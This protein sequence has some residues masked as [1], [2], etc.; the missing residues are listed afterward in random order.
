MGPW[1]QYKLDSGISHILVD[2][3]QDTNSEQWR[4]VDA[5]VEDFFN[6][7]S[8]AQRPRTVFAVGDQKQSIF[9]FQGADPEL[10]IDT[11][12]KYALRAQTVQ[13]AFR[14]VPL[15]TSFRTLRN[16]LGAVDQVFT[17]DELRQGVLAVDEP[18]G[19]DTARAE[20]G[21]LVTLWPPIQ[22]IEEPVDPD[23]WPTQ[24][25]DALTKNAPRRVAERIAREIRGWLDSGRPLGPRGRA[26]KADDILILVQV[27]SVLFHEIIR[28]LVRAGIPTPG[29]DRL[30]VTTHIGVLDLM[31]LGDVLLNP[32]DDLQLAALLRSPLFEVSEDELLALA[33]PRPEKATLWSAMEQSSIPSVAAAYGQIKKWR[34]R[35]DFERPF[36]FFSEVLYAAGGLKKFRARLGAEIDDVAAQFLDLALNHEQSEQPSLQGFL[37]ELR[38]R[39]III[40]RELAEAGTGVRVMTVHG[41]KGLEAPIVILADAATTEKGRGGRTIYMSVVPPLFFHASADRLH[42]PETREDKLEADEA[43]KREY[44]RKLYVAMTR[45]EDELYVTG[46]LTKQGKVEGSWYEAIEQ[47]L[48]PEAE[49]LTD[50]EG[51][52]SALVYPAQRDAPMPSGASAEAGATES[53]TPS[54]P[55][56]PSYRLRRIVRP[57]SAFVDADPARVLETTV[58]AI[59]ATQDPE[60]A[61][62]KGLALHALLQHL[63]RID[64]ALRPAVAAK[65]LPVL[66]PGHPEEHAALAAKAQS[67]LGSASFADLFGP[68]SRAEVPILAQGRRGSQPVTI[69]GRI[70]RLLVEPGR[71]LIVDFKSDANVPSRGASGLSGAARAICAGCRPAL[72][73]PR[74]RSRD[75][76]D[77]PGIIDESEF[78][79]H[80]AGSFRLHHRVILLV[81]LLDS[82]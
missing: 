39:E 38:S 15:Q 60:T 49:S 9:S 65:A 70:D 80:C 41:A 28:A 75:F 62:L 5:L 54:L 34:A 57:S 13:M 66:L 53:V 8:A 1:V 63:S 6:G 67:I 43:Q 46:Y 73:Q 18:V 27:R 17:R 2:E 22:E 21:G 50:A 20:A 14:R 26:V 44:W 11:G 45:A 23:N 69:A 72:P 59:V 47:A 40:K 29:A 77:G 30:A 51:Q 12:R 32:A 37:A 79:D 16:V 82:S 31:A 10:F 7:E 76:V 58:E 35:R 71:V 61:R 64:P 74:C 78:G 4:V 52:E 36:N 81:A 42:V 19:H 24:A 55:P 3:S 68:N 48:R 56:L 25:P 33:Q